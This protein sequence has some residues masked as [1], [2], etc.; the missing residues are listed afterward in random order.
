[1][2]LSDIYKTSPEIFVTLPA[3]QQQ[4]L[5]ISAGVIDVLSLPSPI[6]KFS[7]RETRNYEDV[8]SFHGLS[9]KMEGELTK[10]IIYYGNGI[11]LFVD[12]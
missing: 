1:M 2:K 7:I 12:V 11:T 5:L 9:A 8:W 10:T 4:E 3:A 6:T